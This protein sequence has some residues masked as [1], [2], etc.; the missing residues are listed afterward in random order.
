MT[1]AVVRSNCGVE[2]FAPHTWVTGELQPTNL[3]DWYGI[4][5]PQT[6]EPYPTA[7]AYIDRVLLY[8][9]RGESAPEP[10]RV[11]PIC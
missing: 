5:D 4:A 3:E 10:G 2:S 9:G 8:E 1:D 11:L 6:G 7:Q